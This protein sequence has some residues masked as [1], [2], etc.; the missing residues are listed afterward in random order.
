MHELSI[1]STL[2]ESVLEFVEA[3][4]IRKVLNVRL[5][6]GELTCVEEEQMRFCYSALTE[7]TTIEGSV[8]EIEKVRAEVNCPHCMYQGTPKYWEDALC[9]APVPTLQCPKCGKAAEAA[10][11]HECAIKTIKYVT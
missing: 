3:H 10:R 4:Q 6:V 2:V 11:G 1:V 8:L 9:Q 5:A 7:K